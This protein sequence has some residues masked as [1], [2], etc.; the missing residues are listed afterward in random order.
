MHDCSDV[1]AAFRERLHGN[2]KAR[3]R[4]VLESPSDD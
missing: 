4:E 1:T 3:C 2:E